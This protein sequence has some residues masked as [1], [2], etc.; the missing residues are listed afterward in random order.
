[1]HNF[2]VN[3]F[4]IVSISSYFLK[5]DCWAVWMV[6]T[7]SGTHMLTDVGHIYTVRCAHIYES[8]V[9]GRLFIDATMGDSQHQDH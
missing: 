4:D 2:L 9:L 5:L 6:V 1:M 8:V 7:M 3:P